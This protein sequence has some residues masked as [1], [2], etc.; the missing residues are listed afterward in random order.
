VPQTRR[1]TLLTETSFVRRLRLG[2]GSVFWSRDG[3]RFARVGQCGELGKGTG[4]VMQLHR[5][6][7]LIVAFALWA[8]P[9]FAQDILANMRICAA[10]TDDAR[11][12]ACYDQ[13]IQ[14]TGAPRNAG[15]VPT[16]PA[17]ASSEERFGMTATLERKRQSNQTARPDAP[18][19]LSGRIA[20]VAY[21]PR[22]EAV[23]SL[24]NGQMWEE[25]EVESHVALNPGDAITITRGLLGSFW[26]SADK[27]PRLRVRR[28]R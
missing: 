26:L 27:M 2:V 13:Q 17:A 8:L 3:T 9:A 5:K 7:W 6:Q 16:E 23:I 11:R 22:G 18:D 1:F 20:A 19:K 15:T 4:I 14:R 25:A 12:L 21:K 28:V 10:E 24:E